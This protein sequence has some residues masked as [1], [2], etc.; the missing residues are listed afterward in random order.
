[1]IAAAGV[2][3]EERATGAFAFCLRRSLRTGSRSK[4]VML[5]SFRN[6]LLDSLG[7]YSSPPK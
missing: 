7:N 6:W 4:C 3:G 1:M 2:V 5:T